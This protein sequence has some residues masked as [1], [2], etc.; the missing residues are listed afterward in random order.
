MTVTNTCAIG[1]RDLLAFHDLKLMEREGSGIDLLFERLLTSGRRAPTITGGT[2]CVHSTV[3]R[4]VVRPGVD[5]P[6]R[7][8]ASRPAQP[9]GGR[10]ESQASAQ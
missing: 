4:R 8:A 9:A 7:R 3:P 1:M 5:R 10:S 6:R 2:Y